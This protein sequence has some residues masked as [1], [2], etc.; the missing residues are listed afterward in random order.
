MQVV[1]Y[2]GN[3]SAYIA[4]KAFKA[5][6]YYR[7]ARY[8]YQGAKWAAPKIARAYRAYKARKSMSG[9]KRTRSG[10]TKAKKTSEF[11]TSMEQVGVPYCVGN[12]KRTLLENG[13]GT[14]S[15]RTMYIWNT[16]WIEGTNSNATA[17]NRR[18]RQLCRVKGCSVKMHMLNTSGQRLYVNMALVTPR[19]RNWIVGQYD[20][21][22]P[23]DVSVYLVNNVADF[24]RYTV[25]S[26]ATTSVRSRAYD[27]RGT[28]SQ[29]INY[30]FQNSVDSINTDEF[31]VHER[32]R[33]LLERNGGTGTVVDTNYAQNNSI[34]I[35]EYFKIDRQFRYTSTSGSPAAPAP[36][37]VI[38]VESP[39][40]GNEETHTDYT[41]VI[42]TAVK[43]ETFFRDVEGC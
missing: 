30:G 31:I 36:H 5:A 29:L 34:E 22:T 33:W 3:A 17:I 2:S 26:P 9:S 1:P 6:P 4:G 38:W 39:I 43:I 24:F 20:G 16:C 42:T 19:T 35:D 12:N 14:T 18:T 10:T 8:A 41:D 15:G 37:L 32:K 7:N 25:V 21:N 23:L 27:T 40:G 11:N 13:L 28:E